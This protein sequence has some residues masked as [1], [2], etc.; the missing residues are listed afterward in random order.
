MAAT[1]GEILE[2]SLENLDYLLDVM[3]A[4]S[5]QMNDAERLRI[6][7]DTDRRVTRNLNDLRRFNRHNLS[8]AENRKRW[9]R[10][11]LKQWYEK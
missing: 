3:T 5:M 11:P 1:Y 2:E 9:D 7:H 8:I 10:Q 4:F 6:I